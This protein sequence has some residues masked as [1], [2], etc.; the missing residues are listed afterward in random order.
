[1]PRYPRTLSHVFKVHPVN[2]S[3]IGRA[4]KAAIVASGQATSQACS[5][6]DPKPGDSPV[7][8]AVITAD[9]MILIKKAI[10]NGITNAARRSMN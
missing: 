9:M 4:T 2:R 10:Q 5:Q 6:R 7:F 3:A 8:T 1:M